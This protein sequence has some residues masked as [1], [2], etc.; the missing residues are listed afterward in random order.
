MKKAAFGK[1]AAA[2]LALLLALSC[3]ACA[4]PAQQEPAQPTETAQQEQPAETPAAEE[5]AAAKLTPGTYSETVTA[6]NGDMTVDVVLSENAIED[7]VVTDHMES[8]ALGTVG[9]DNAKND[10]LTYQTLN[11]DTTAGATISSAAL[12]MAVAKAIEE[13]GGSDSDW[14]AEI[15][16]DTAVPADVDCDLV[17]VGSGT[18]GMSAA[19]Q[20]AELGLNAVLVEQLGFLGGSSCRTGYIIGGDTRL[21]AE[22]GITFTTDDMIKQMTKGDDGSGNQELYNHDVAVQ[23]AKLFGPDIDWLQEKGVQF[24]VIKSNNQFR[25]PDAARLGPYL[26]TGMK[27]YLD[28]KGFDYRLNTRA[29]EVLMENGAAVGVKVEDK[30]GSAYT[31]HAKNVIL[32][33][34]GYNASE[35]MAKIYNPEFAGMAYCVTLGADGS[36]IM[37][38]KEA[39]AAL[40]CMDQVSYHPFAAMYN[41]AS[42][43]L[44]TA[45]NAGA[46]AVNGDGERFCN[47]KGDTLT[48]TRTILAE[49]SGVYCI[50]DQS[51]MDYDSVK[52]DVGQ[53]GIPQMY[54]KADTLE[55]LAAALGINA[56][57]LK[58]TVAEY[59]ACVDKG[60]DMMF[61]KGA[62][63]LT[64]NYANGPYYGVKAAPE[65]LTCYG[66]VVIDANGCAQTEA[67]ETI[68]GLYVIGEASCSFVL[69]AS[70]NTVS[71]CQGRLSVQHAADSLK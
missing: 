1:L 46:I 16:Q 63:Y 55:E 4:A 25:G 59:G 19:T 9:M 37:M 44:V 7:I 49:E 28:E 13:A 11:I 42:R 34:G 29:T 45:M 24:G 35:E 53:S 3:A 5:P 69:G 43:S 36:G 22:Q 66:G 40:K 31:I 8:L 47:E 20:A 12:R 14:M 61:G 27:D 23:Y 70:F 51:L 2:L 6:H 21:Q 50:L 52:N 58:A 32:A 39:G 30:N 17:I 48:L 41:G 60:E 38:A 56:E 71:V 54:T 67:G 64:S 62:S 26:I 15:P 57:N 18:A 65:T 33:T 10:I 68:P